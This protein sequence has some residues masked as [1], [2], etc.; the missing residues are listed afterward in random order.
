MKLNQKAFDQ[1][2][3][4]IKKAKVEKKT[5]WTE[6]QPSTEVE[7][8]FLEKEGWD[9]YASWYLGID[10]SIEEKSKAHFDFPYGDYESVHRSALI[11]AKQQASQYDYTEIE[12]A[13]NHLLIQIDKKADAV[14]EASDQSFPASDPPNWRE[15]R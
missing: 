15:R 3:R 6:V 10:E 13:V 12:N 7:N 14:S 9:Q 11:A 5:N 2:K 4:L 8:E 1:A